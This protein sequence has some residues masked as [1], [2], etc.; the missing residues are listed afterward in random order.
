MRFFRYSK[1]L[2][3]ITFIGLQLFSFVTAADTL[4]D[5]E[6]NRIR[7]IVLDDLTAMKN[8][9]FGKTSAEFINVFGGN[10]GEDLYRY[11]KSHIL[12]FEWG[13]NLPS[14]AALAADNTQTMYL[15]SNYAKLQQIQRIGTL[16]HEAHHAEPYSWP[17]IN[18]PNNL[19]F[20]LFGIYIDN[21]RENGIGGTPN[22]DLDSKGAYAVEYV[23]YRAIV[24]SC[25][26][27]SYETKLWAGYSSLGDGILRILDRKSAEQLVIRSNL[28]SVKELTQ[29]ILTQ[30]RMMNDCES[31]KVSDC[32]LKS[33]TAVD[34]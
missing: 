7:N 22:C 3:Q 27:C 33:N 2:V 31:K 14:A 18:C 11:F 34:P 29:E 5:N 28:R 20:K 32:V 30:I 19:D 26:N 15:A 24:E 9:K 23:F 6:F 16:L 10:S 1:F 25:I 17:H 13:T 4:D 12:R 8:L 21:K